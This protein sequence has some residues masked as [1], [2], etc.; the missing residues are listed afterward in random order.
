MSMSIVE[1]FEPK[2]PSHVEEQERDSAND[3]KVR[4][5]GRGL[6]CE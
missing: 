3:G 1:L 4:E 2:V 5:R 6:L